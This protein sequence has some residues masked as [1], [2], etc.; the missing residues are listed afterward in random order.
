MIEF[1]EETAAAR[2][3][4]VTNN[5][6]LWTIPSHH[7]YVADGED[8]LAQTAAGMITITKD[9]FRSDNV[10]DHELL[11]RSRPAR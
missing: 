7:D 3:F 1:D 8:R 6:G 9:D 2:P 4:K 11:G 10:A 5:N